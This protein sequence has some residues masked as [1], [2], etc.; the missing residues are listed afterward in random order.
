MLPDG[1]RYALAAGPTLL[2]RA[3]GCTVQLADNRVS[4]RHALIEVVD[5][6]H[7]I[8]DLGSTNGTTVNDDPLTEP[9]ALTPGDTISL[10][11]LVL[12]FDA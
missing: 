4:R 10:G 1:Q 5:T 12:R 8:T 2:G 7:V 6:A 11:G 9:R 3:P